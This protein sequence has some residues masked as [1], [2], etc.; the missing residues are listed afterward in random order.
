MKIKLDENLGKSIKKIF[1]DNGFDVLNVFDQNILGCSDNHLYNLVKLEKRCLIT[2]DKDFADVI[3]F[4][5]I[6]TYGIIVLRLKGK[7][8]LNLIEK[9]IHNFLEYLKREE[10]INNTWIVEPDKI[11]IHQ[12]E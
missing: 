5:P 2:L 4:D 9:M 6:D 1:E 10:P 11:R 3:R 12:R 8:N 7:I